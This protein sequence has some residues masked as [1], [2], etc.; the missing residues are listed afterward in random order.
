MWAVFCP[1]A[2]GILGNEAEKIKGVRDLRLVTV[3]EPSPEPL[4]EPSR[5]LIFTSNV[6]LTVPPAESGPFMERLPQDLRRRVAEVMGEPQRYWYDHPVPVGAR[7]EANE[8]LYGL[9]GLDQAL[10]FEK[11]RGTI[12]SRARPLCILSVSVTHTGLQDAA[13][14]YLRSELLGCGGFDHLRIL[15]FTEAD[16]R[17]LVREVLAPAASSYLD[18]PAAEQA[19]EVFGVD[20]E[21][22]R[23]YSFLKAIAALWQALVDPRIKAVFKIDLDQIF[24][25]EA[26]VRETGASALEHLSSPLWGARGLDRRGRRVDLEM[27]AGALVNREDADK[28]VFT[29][30]VTFPQGPASA[31]E[32]AFFSRLPQALS[33]EAEMGARYGGG[34][35]DGVHTCMERIHVTGGT[36]GIRVDGLRH[37]RPFTPSFI[38]RAEDQAYIMSSMTRPGRRPAYLHKPGLIMR[39]DKDLLAA[40]AVRSA[41]GSKVIGDHVR[42]LLFSEYAC[43]LE[44]EVDGLKQALAPFTG[45][46]ISKIPRTV[47][48][49]SYA[50][51]AA[52]FFDS[53]EEQ[54]GERFVREG[55]SRLR[56]ALDFTSGD[57]S[58]LSQAYQAEQ[59]AWDLY[60]DCLSEMEKRLAQAEGTAERLKKAVS[61]IIKDC[62]LSLPGPG[63]GD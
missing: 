55:T 24:P 17:R 58:P 40:E 28:S 10:A 42:I 31:E 45:A 22:G 5:E 1:E 13:K 26:L 30:D 44:G 2:A 48:L 53:C 15:A 56:R 50:L 52:R 11:A 19:L 57:P 33:T 7:P 36:T 54:E 4:R 25:Q 39:H 23:H 62:E 29:P 38:G 14:E 61:R 18:V 59:T 6:L 41:A 46:F 51:R 16:A 27:I 12:P 43:A 60:Y 8:I 37:H 9:R 63:E 47:A 3:N 20:G 35:P 49:L 34:V 32:L 21:Y